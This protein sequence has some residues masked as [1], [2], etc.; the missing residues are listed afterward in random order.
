V[1]INIELLEWNLRQ[2]FLDVHKVWGIYQGEYGCF[3]VFAGSV[4]EAINVAIKEGIKHPKC[5]V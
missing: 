2:C 5:V 4:P 1:T 3:E